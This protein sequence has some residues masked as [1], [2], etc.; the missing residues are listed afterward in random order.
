MLEGR[1][2]VTDLLYNCCPFTMDKTIPTERASQAKAVSSTSPHKYVVV[3]V[4]E[5]ELAQEE[6]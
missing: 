5:P 1:W 2:C 4:S 6:T 3:Q